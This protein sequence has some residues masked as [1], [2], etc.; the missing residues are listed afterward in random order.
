M[1]QTP[2]CNRAMWNRMSKRTREANTYITRISE[3][4]TKAL[5]SQAK[6][7]EKL[8]ESTQR[9][10]K[11]IEEKGIIEKKDAVKILGQF[12]E[13]EKMG[14]DSFNITATTLQECN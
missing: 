4:N 5:I 1:L 2:R 6:M 9:M 8:R 12:K 3:V 13:V 10:R 7:L 11:V 14:L